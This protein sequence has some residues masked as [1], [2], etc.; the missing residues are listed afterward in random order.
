MR[1]NFEAARK[2]AELAS[3]VETG[4]GDFKENLGHAN[5]ALGS[6]ATAVSEINQASELINKTFAKKLNKF[7]DNFSESV[8]RLGSFQNDLRT[9]YQKL[10]DES[11]AFQSGIRQTLDLQNSRLENILKTLKSYEGAY[12]A[13]RGK[14]DSKLQ[15]FL[16]EATEASTS[17]NAQNREFMEQIRN[18]LSTTL[19]GIGNNLNVNLS[20][21]AQ[22]FD[23]F[24]VPI[25]HAAEKIEGS[26]E[27]FYK[28]MR[29]IITNLQGEIQKQNSNYKDHLISLIETKKRIETLLHHLSESSQ[30][31]A[32]ETQGLTLNINKLTQD[33]N[34]LSSNIN[35]LSSNANTFN[36]YVGAI[37]KSIQ[38]LGE[39]AQR[40][41]KVSNIIAPLSN[42]INDFSV[43]VKQLQKAIFVPP[44]TELINIRK[45]KAKNRLS[46]L[47]FWRKEK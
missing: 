23:S 14:I 5:L 9:L 22:R 34:S 40:L 10:V 6:L 39:G 28:L 30:L 38:S 18:Q 46:K 1:Q 16:D 3:S 42:T 43:A 19:D 25:K 41:G 7:S 45:P 32:T 27:N 13:E 8:Q 33:V 12:I 26:Q 11:D 20:K 47:L 44:K 2:V 24:D 4:M 37:E 36:N 17:I 29:E 35:S 15:K 31:Q 21:I